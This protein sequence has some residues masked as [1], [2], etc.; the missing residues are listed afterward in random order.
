VAFL[1]MSEADTFTLIKLAEMKAKGERK[2]ER[3]SELAA[4]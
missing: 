4:C 1:R 3:I 2:N